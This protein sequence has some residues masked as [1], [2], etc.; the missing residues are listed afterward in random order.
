MIPQQAY[1]SINT[2][3]VYIPSQAKDRTTRKRHTTEFSKVTNIKTKK[4]FP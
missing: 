3:E 1:I 2:W 4:R